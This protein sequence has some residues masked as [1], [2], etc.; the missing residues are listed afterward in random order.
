[1]FR[2]VR[3]YQFDT[4]WPAS[5]E[6]LSKAL[7]SSAFQPC[8]PLTERSSGWEPV[9]PMA[10]EALAR[11]LNGAD[12]MR[13]RSQSRVLPPAAVNEALEAELEDY[14]KRT[15]EEPS[16]REKK[17]LKN[18]TREKLLTQALLKSDRVWGYMDLGEKII[19]VDAATPSNA[20]RFLQSLYL[21]LN[22]LGASKPEL[23]PVKYTKPLGDLLRQM[24]LGKL[25]ERFNLGRECK[26]QDA[27][28]AGSTVRWADFDLND[29][30]IR[31]H[32]ADGMRLTHLAIEYDHVLSCVINENGI[33]SKL[34]LLG[35]DNKAD[36]SDEEPLAKLDA[37]FVLLSGILRQLRK[38]LKELLDGYA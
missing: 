21:P 27:T 28:E 4:D 3:F 25:P 5:E 24:F 34:R 2:N 30:T 6:A 23:R 10:G 15:Q 37:Q 22:E 8:G 20:E 1:M 35:M 26:M 9:D 16:R 38:D 32:V 13:L 33:L 7:E 14:R 31:N 18:E 29:S 11:R 36:I 17:R 19:A 12:L